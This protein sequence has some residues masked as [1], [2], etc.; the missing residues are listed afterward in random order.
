VTA[1]GKMMIT[2]PVEHSIFGAT[3]YIA[4]RDIT[5]AFTADFRLHGKNGEARR[6]FVKKA[7]RYGL[8]LWQG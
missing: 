7:R 5:V 6:D 4:P 8:E 2:K 1:L 3:A